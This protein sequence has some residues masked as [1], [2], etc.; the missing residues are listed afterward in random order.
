VA[1]NNSKLMQFFI[2]GWNPWNTNWI[3]CVWNEG[4]R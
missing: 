1:V 4:Y 2:F 3:I